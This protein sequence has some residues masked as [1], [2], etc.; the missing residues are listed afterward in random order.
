MSEF[1]KYQHIER[2][3]TAAVNGL[4][5]G[6]CYIFPKIDGTNGS[7]FYKDGEVRFGSRNRELTLENDNGGFYNQYKDDVAFKEYFKENPNHIIYGEFLI[8]HSL[9]TYRDDTWRKFYVFDVM[10]GDRYLTYHE[11]R[12]ILEEYNID[13]IVPIAIVDYPTEEKL[14]EMLEKNTFL[15]KDGCGTGEG[16]VIKRYDFVNRFGNAVWGKI[17]TSEFKEKHTREMGIIKLTTGLGV[18]ERICEKYITSALIEKEIAK[19][20]LEGAGWDSKLIPKLI[21]VIYYSLITEEMWNIIKTFKNPTIDFKRL[22]T[23]MIKEIK[24]KKPDLF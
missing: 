20:E 15:I 17:V 22:H 16:I 14:Y 8:P 1:K 6:L 4:L 23:I 10:D 3:G 24:T 7:V 2:I 13:F 11:Y 12:P 5:D 19:I 9:K 18:E 21:G